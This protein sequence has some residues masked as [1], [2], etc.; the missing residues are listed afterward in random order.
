MVERRHFNKG[1]EVTD[2]KLGRGALAFE[3]SGKL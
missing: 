1:V 2:R 3:L